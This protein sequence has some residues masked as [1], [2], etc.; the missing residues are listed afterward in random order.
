MNTASH[1]NIVGCWSENGHVH[2]GIRDHRTGKETVA[3]LTPR[4]AT[5][6]AAHLSFAVAEATQ[7]E[8][9]AQSALAGIAHPQVLRRSR[10]GGLEAA[11]LGAISLAADAA[12]EKAAV[13]LAK[14][15]GQ[16]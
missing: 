4:R 6:L 12:R 14:A 9:E 7:H 3:A 10:L 8:A 11:D 16:R 13:V 15:A 5:L 2:L 1:L